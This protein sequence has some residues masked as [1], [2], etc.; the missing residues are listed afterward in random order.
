MWKPLKFRVSRELKITLFF[1][2]KGSGKSLLNAWLALEL[3]RQYKIM[4]QRYP[5][6]AKRKYY[7]N[8]KLS[9]EIEKRFGEQLVYWN[10]PRELY[11]VRDADISWDEIGKDF[12]ASSWNETPKEVKQIFSHL[13][14]R[15][16]R[17]F[18]NTQVFEDID[19]S[20]RRQVDFAYYVRKVFGSVDVTA[21]LP[22]PKFIYGF[23]AIK[24]FDP[25]MLEREKKRRIPMQFF[26]YVLRISRKLISIYDTGEELPPFMPDRVEH[27]ILPC[28]VIGCRGHSFIRKI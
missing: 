13:R 22:P 8:G 5:V 21:T 14:K 6:L 2:K 12:P 28:G 4:S 26:P 23:I 9:S 19:V 16:N 25:L 15:G 20:F 7:A 18:A 24:Q 3:L 27:K 1:G 11:R 17:L 10:N